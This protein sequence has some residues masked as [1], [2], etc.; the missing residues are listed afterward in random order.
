MDGSQQ[1]GLA[2]VP[3]ESQELGK[4]HETTQSLQPGSRELQETGVQLEASARPVTRPALIIRQATP[5]RPAAGPKGLGHQPHENYL[6][7]YISP[8][9]ASFQAWREPAASKR[10]E[11]SRGRREK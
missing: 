6:I 3:P 4:S 8:S 9:W 11:L 7:P 2:S 1:K 5:R 10:E